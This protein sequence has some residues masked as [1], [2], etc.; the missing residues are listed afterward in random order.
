MRTSPK[1]CMKKLNIKLEDLRQQNL[2]EL[3]KI[4]ESVFSEFEVE[5]YILGAMAREETNRF[6]NHS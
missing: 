6:A 3:F 5:F 1:P 2:K 4:L